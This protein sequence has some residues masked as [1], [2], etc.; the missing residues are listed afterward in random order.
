[1]RKRFHI[2]ACAL[3]AVMA[4]SGV[5]AADR[6]PDL[7]LSSGAMSYLHLAQSVSDYN[8]YYRFWPRTEPNFQV[9]T[10][11]RRNSTSGVTV[12]ENR[13][14]SVMRVCWT[15]RFRDGSTNR[16][17]GTLRPG[18]VRVASCWACDTS[19]QHGGAVGIEFTTV[20]RQ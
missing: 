1:M 8:C 13:T 10:C 17:C 18:E 16:A 20:E 6:L 11:N 14:G 19:T 2:A 15:L 12:Q 9:Y 7:Q 5:F 3:A 4:G